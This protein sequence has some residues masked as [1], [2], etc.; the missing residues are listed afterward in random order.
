MKTYTYNENDVAEVTGAT[1]S[2]TQVKKLMAEKRR[3]TIFTNQIPVIKNG[4]RFVGFDSDIEFSFD[5]FVGAYR[6]NI[7]ELRD[8]NYIKK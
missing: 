7:K 8:V 2:K 4:K 1:L 3:K 6:E 5:S